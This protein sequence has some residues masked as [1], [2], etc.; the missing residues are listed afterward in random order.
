[1]KQ[2]SFQN[3]KNVFI[4]KNAI[5]KMSHLIPQDTSQIFF[6]YDKKMTKY[7]RPIKLSLEKLPYPIF[8]LAVNA[9]ESLK[10]ITSIQNICDFL[11]NKKA[12]RKSMLVA[13][14]GGTV[15]DTIG[16][17]A[18]IYLRGI[19]WIN[20][21]TTLLAAVDSAMGGK[22]GINYQGS[23]NILGAF[24]SPQGIIIDPLFF[25]SLGHQE[26]V[27]G[28]GEMIKYSVTFDPAFFQYIEN[29]LSAILS[30]K[31]K[32]LI[33]VVRRSLYW[34]NKIVKKDPLD[35]SGV[36]ELLNFGHTFG[37]ALES[38][39]NFKTIQHGEAV[40]WGIKFAA[41]LSHQ[42]NMI[43]L[44]DLIKVSALIKK[45]KLTPLPENMH[46]QFEK[47]IKFMMKDKKNI[48]GEFRFV[49]LQKIGK[50]QSRLKVS[51]EEITE[52]LKNLDLLNKNN[53]QNKG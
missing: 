11:I 22:T 47:L 3:I 40:L 44:K 28:L 12:D 24:H 4:E 46:L 33:Y 18:A 30:K 41:L 15:G 8:Y 52:T 37:H 6:V 5:K 34:K 20:I 19:K 7:L 53:S 50:A 2:T 45:I 38:L 9:G 26:I 48:N 16:F 14:G 43:S 39:F 49:L 13:F 29:N 51:R 21:P 35:Q 32:E 31:E 36:R 10:E 23:K 1:M 17:T 42:K 27:S 25:Q